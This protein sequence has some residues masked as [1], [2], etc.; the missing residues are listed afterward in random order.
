MRKSAGGFEALLLLGAAVFGAAAQGGPVV[1]SVVVAI[2][3]EAG[4]AN[5]EGLVPIAVGQAYSLKSVDDAVKQ[6]FKT[7]LF[8]DI[9]VLKEGEREVHLT[10]VLTRKRLVGRVRFRGAEGVRRSLLTENL[11]ALRPQSDFSEERLRRGAEEIR[12]ALRRQGYLDAEVRPTPKPDP[13]RPVVDVDFEIAAGPRFTIREVAIRGGPAE[14]GGLA[15]VMAT[16]A[17]APYIPAVVN[18]DLARIKGLLNL[19]GYPRADVVLLNRVFHQSDRTVSL[20]IQ[21]EPNE[22][23]RIEIRGADLDEALVRPIWEERVFERWGINQAEAR[24]LTEL[25]R[26]GYVLAMIDSRIET[27]PE[28]IRILHEVDPGRK[29]R[30][31]DIA[32]EGATALTASDLRRELGI[33]P[34]LPLIGG[35]SGERLFEIPELIESLYRSRGYV[36]TLATLNF[37]TDGGSLRAVFVVDEGPQRRISTLELR[38]SAIVSSDVLR[39]VIAAREG[40]PYDPPQVRRDAERLE[41]HYANLGFRGTR[42]EASAAEETENLFRVV[43]EIEEGKPALIDRIVIAGNAVTRRSVVEDQLLVREGRAPRADLILESQRRLER[44]GVFSEVKIEEVPSGDGF[45]TLVVGVREGERN[46]VGFGTG[47]ETLS[48]AVTFEFWNTSLRPRGTAEFVRANMFGRAALLSLVGQFSLAEK[49]AVVSWDEPT[50][51]GWPFRASLNAWFEREERVSY[52]FDRR[53][54]SLTASREI[55]PDWTSLTTV[56]YA[57]TTLY[58]LEIPESEIDRQF[59]PY[60]TTSISEN[61]IWDR[62]DDPFNPEKGFFLGGDLELAYPLFSAESD[63]IKTYVKFQRFFPLWPGGNL[64][65]TG[66]LGL[67]LGRMPIHERFFGGGANSFRGRLF[68]ELGPRDPQSDNPV[69][70][71][72]LAILNLEFRWSLFS[73]LP[74]FSAAVFYDKGNIFA[75]RNELRP[76]RLEDAVGL[77]IRYRTPLGPLRFDLGWNLDRSYAGRNPLV[78]V[79]I[80]NVF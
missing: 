31:S 52:G 72:A 9:R 55:A 63:Y 19:R 32:F 61:L 49:R 69:G 47:F 66:R 25:R 20:V 12:E 34:R 29:Y 51:F 39:T 80:G 45:L 65:A 56:R 67:G 17:G 70:G 44:L 11:F 33:P 35:I 59:F 38:G 26:R 48:R 50:L 14:S 76:G 36:A 54:V 2:E 1:S 24:L 6:V 16:R 79:T 41:T 30:I 42:V 77:G 60:S 3:G 4:A 78:F 37:R 43:F 18:E 75:H 28:E 71:K 46:Y 23:I 15:E 68:D 62:R 7:G 5:V 21:A 13:L 53:G 73:G 57:R 74:N 40:G 8:S 64:S 27:G 22:R 58:F 10:V